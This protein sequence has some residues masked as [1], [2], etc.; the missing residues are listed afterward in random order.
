MVLLK[1][2]VQNWSAY[3]GKGFT[4]S[5]ERK[6]LSETVDSA[7]GTTQWHLSSRAKSRALLLETDKY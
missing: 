3:Y 4:T 2:R 1:H 5:L 6:S 7:I